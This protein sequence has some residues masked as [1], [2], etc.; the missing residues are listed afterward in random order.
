MHDS[1]IGNLGRIQ[2]Q[3][4]KVF[5]PSPHDAHIGSL[6]QVS[7]QEDVTVKAESIKDVEAFSGGLALSLGGNLPLVSSPMRRSK[8]T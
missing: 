1:C 4:A 5:Q 6:A 7:A 3:F 2:V 8:S